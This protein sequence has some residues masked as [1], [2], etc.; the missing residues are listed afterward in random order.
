MADN[1][2]TVDIVAKLDRIE[3]QLGDFKKDASAAGEEAGNAFANNFATKIVAVFGAIQIG[4]LLKGTFD[5]AIEEATAAERA[6]TQ[7]NASLAVSG[8]FSQ[9]ASQ[10]FEAYAKSLQDTLGIS[11]DLIISNAS[12]LASLGQLSGEG[13]E[14]ATQASL[15]LAATGLLSL[16]SAFNLVAKAASG[17]VEALGRYGIKIDEN[18]PKSERFEAA[19]AQIEG[20]LGGLSGAQVNTFEGAINRLSVS[21]GDIFETLGK[22]ITQSPVVIAIISKLSVVF[23]DLTKS[24]GAQS[25]TSFVDNLI[26]SLLSLGQTITSYVIKPL[27]ILFNLGKATFSALV[28][29]GQ[30]LLTV[31]LGFPALITELVGKLIQ[32]GS[33]LGKI[34]GIFN[35][36]LGRSLTTMLSTFGQQTQ[37]FGNNIRTTL[38]DGLVQSASDTA[39]AFGESFSLTATPAI[40]N[41]IGELQNAANT[42]QPV[43]ETIKNSVGGAFNEVSDTAIKA[44]AKINQA[45]QQGV[46]NTIS[47]GAQAIGASLI[48]GGKAFDNFK[49]QVLSIIGD[50]AIQIGT[51]LIG[52]GIGIE[53]LKVALGTLSGGVAI[54]AGLALIAIGG[55]L[56]SLSAGAGADSGG[57]GVGG[58]V[59]SQGTAGVGGGTFGIQPD[60]NASQN[61]TAISVNVQGNILDRRE[62]GLEIAAV[63]Q[64][65]FNT[66]G[67][68]GVSGA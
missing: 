33:V 9:A 28:T 48:K 34:V 19:L 6:I 62:S 41:F 53:S 37:D 57:T 46:L 3:K 1:Q 30:A 21:F 31:F 17:N 60:V 39:T 24:L 14:R 42:A 29:G 65:H 64:E 63:I 10:S 44:A 15:D 22:F 8:N 68:I 26:K 16:D 40:Q 27:E 32:M 67:N 36:D 23:Q 58:G 43:A 2:I 49:N 45:F 38:T 20:R 56:K 13:L 7:L 25:G 66:N 35:E 4:K 59:G 47:V 61:G 54:A 51:T 50:M 55:L 5:R 18:I 52:I 11:D 12:I